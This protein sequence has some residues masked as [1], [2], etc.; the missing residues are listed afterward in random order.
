MQK[1][2]IHINQ[3]CDY[4]PSVVLSFFWVVAADFMEGLRQTET[5]NKIGSVLSDGA[6]TLNV[7]F[8]FTVEAQFQ[9]YNLFNMKKTIP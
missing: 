2:C 1:S 4:I 6:K 3:S 7:G 9:A 8:V 5:F